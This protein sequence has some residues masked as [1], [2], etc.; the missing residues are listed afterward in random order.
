LVRAD[1]D[2]K[3]DRRQ[4]HLEWQPSANVG[5]GGCAPGNQA[6]M[7]VTVNEPAARRAFFT[8]VGSALEWL[9][10]ATAKATNRERDHLSEAERRPNMKKYSGARSHFIA[11][12][13][14]RYPS[15]LIMFLGNQGHFA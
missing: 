4:S 14:A 7:A 10:L 5:T 13:K 1:Q 11:T 9:D 8:R 2:L 12:T 6:L 15:C 3:K